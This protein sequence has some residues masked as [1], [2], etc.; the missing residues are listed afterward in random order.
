MDKKLLKRFALCGLALLLAICFTP[1][2]ALQAQ[3]QPDVRIVYTE[4]QWVWGPDVHPN[5]TETWGWMRVAADGDHLF[6]F[7]AS[8]QDWQGPTRPPIETLLRYANA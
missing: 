3:V 5:A 4:W 7:G 6:L 1:A 2:A 8:L